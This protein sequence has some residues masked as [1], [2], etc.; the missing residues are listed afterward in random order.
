MLMAAELTKL[1]SDTCLENAAKAFLEQS[2][3]NHMYTIRGYRAPSPR[4]EFW[5]SS[6]KRKFED[7]LFDQGAVLVQDNGRCHLAFFDER[8]MTLFILKWMT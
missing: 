1:K 2:G 8:Q 3:I 4:V 5:D 7:W 6:R